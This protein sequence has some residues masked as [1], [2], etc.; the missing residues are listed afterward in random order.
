MS[1]HLTVAYM[2]SRWDPKIHWFMQ[3]LSHEM[4]RAAIDYTMLSVVVVDFWHAERDLRRGPH[5]EMGERP[6]VLWQVNEHWKHVAP[7]PNVWQ[8]EHRRTKVDWFAAANARNTALCLAPDGWIAYVDDLSVLMPG[9]LERVREAM[10]SNTITFGAYKKVKNLV[11]EDGVATSYEEFPG[12]IDSRWGKGSDYGP[13]QAAGS[14]LFGCSLAGPVEAFLSVNGWNE[15]CDGLGSEDYITGINLEKKG[16]RFAYDRRMLTLESEELHHVGPIMKRSDY[17]VSPNDKSHAI[18]NA[19][20]HGN[21]WAPNYFGEGGIRALRER[22]L[23][24]EPF[25][26]CRIPEHEWFSRTRLEDL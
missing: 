12:G 17:G 26:V 9:W 3:S 23:A 20:L 22:V 24:G 13:V 7:K 6:N 16:W 14:W 2:T 19:T 25:P 15:S 1:E 21:G 10:K 11:V 5:A 8:G 18:L 4:L